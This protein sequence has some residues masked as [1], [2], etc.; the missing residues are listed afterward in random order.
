MAIFAYARVS[1]AIQDVE[2]QKF[3]ILKYA[4]NKKFQIDEWCSE[5]VSGTKSYKNRELGVI[6]EK[7]KE[8][9]I[10]VISEIS[11]LG[12][13][14]MEVMDCLNQLM[15]KDCKV[16]S[17]KEGFELGD[18]IPAKIM[19]FCFSLSAEIER[20]MIAAR[21]KEALARL[22][23]EGKTLGRPVGSFGKSKLDD[24]RDMIIEFLNK[25]VSKASICK[26]LS[27]C[28]G[29]LNSW[30]LTRDVHIKK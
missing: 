18:N 1:T 2:N 8:G 22:K 6:I 23:A 30:I 5:T 13:S 20:S 4:D 14:L 19:A 7:M 29:T 17:I 15:R 10:L 16:I 24:K 3:E 11:R 28:E 9:D 21:T 26:I 27:C 12:R 25:G